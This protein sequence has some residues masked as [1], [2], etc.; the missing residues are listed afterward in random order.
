MSNDKITP[1]PDVSDMPPEEG[2]T[3]ILNHAA[4][5]GASDLFFTSEFNHVDVS[6]RRYG[7]VRKVM[8]L[9]TDQAKRYLTHIKA[10]TGMDIAERRRPLDGR[11][12]HRLNDGRMV[13]L[14]INTIPTMHGEDFALRMLMRDTELREI[15][16]LG[17]DQHEYNLLIEM[18]NRPSGL[19]LVSGPTGSGKTTTLYACLRHLNDG[20]RKIHTIEDPIEYSIEGM[21][22]SQVN[23][24]IDL[25]FPELLRSIL[26]Q[27]PDIIMIG[28]VRDEVT[29]RTT[30]RAAN[31]GHLVFA[32][33]PAPVA[34]MAVQSIRSLG[35]HPHFL[36]TSLLGVISQRLI[37]TLCPNCREEYDITTAPH[38]FD[39][40]RQWLRD[41]EGKRLYGPKGCEQCENT[42]YAGRAGVFEVMSVSKEIRDLIAKDRPA[43]AIR[44]KAFALGMREFRHSALLKVA[45]GVTSTEE[46]FRVIPTEYLLL[47]D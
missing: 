43:Q 29:A 13:D 45:R 2:V 31:S 34:S 38:T 33:L 25:D 44:D 46:V 36:S 5:I 20:Q 47:D 30:V 22:Q 12:I 6:V 7:I 24:Q 23:S 41:E 9:G 35:V 14:R 18:L 3:A 27:S 19:I 39:A 8:E 15:D 37:R 17:M 10:T 40:V 1:P 32:T 26:R 42:G 4:G 28:E 16:Q 11:W 21:H